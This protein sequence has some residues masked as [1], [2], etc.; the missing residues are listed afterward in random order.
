MSTIQRFTVNFE[1]LFDGDPDASII[2]EPFFDNE[3][4]VQG[5]FSDI[6]EH[7]DEWMVE[8][9]LFEPAD[10]QSL[11]VYFEDIEIVVCDEEVDEQEVYWTLFDTFEINPEL[12]DFWDELFDLS[13]IVNEESVET[14]LEIP[15]GTTIH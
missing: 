1:D 3:D 8:I 7:E 9:T 4:F 5:Y 10:A 2:G 14:D 15:A 12:F 6:F 13:A 11:Y